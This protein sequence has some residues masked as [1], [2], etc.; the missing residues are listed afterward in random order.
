MEVCDAF[1]GLTVG[2]ARLAMHARHRV[3]GFPGGQ[4]APKF[5]AVVPRCTYESSTR[6][7]VL[8]VGAQEIKFDEKTLFVTDAS[9]CKE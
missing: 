8:S 4:N 9:C 3:D 7:R 6:W 5:L 1:V 2:R